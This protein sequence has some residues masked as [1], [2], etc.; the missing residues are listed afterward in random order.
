MSEEASLVVAELLSEQVERHT[1]VERV[2]S[3]LLR[4]VAIREVG[5]KRFRNG[6]TGQWLNG[7]RVV[8]NERRRFDDCP[9][10]HNQNADA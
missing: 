2:A 5:C 10:G 6:L 1:V 3:V 4:E 7:V 9:Y 8:I